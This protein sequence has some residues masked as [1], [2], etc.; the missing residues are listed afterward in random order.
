M[1]IQMGGGG[2]GVRAH[3]ER[4]ILYGRGFRCSLMLS[5]PYFELGLYDA[6]KSRSKFRQGGWS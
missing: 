4:D 6:K 1:I 3:H 5:E 2:G